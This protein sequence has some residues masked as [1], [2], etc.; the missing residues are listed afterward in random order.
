MK[1]E[2]TEFN[3]NDLIRAVV[4]TFKNELRIKHDL[5]IEFN[6]SHSQL[7]VHADRDRIHQVFYN[8]L[9]NAVKF[10]DKGLISISANRTRGNAVRVSTSDSGQGIDEG[11]LPKLFSKFATSSTGSGTGLGLFISQKLIEAHGGRLY[12]VNNKDK[13][14][15][16]QGGRGA[17]FTFILPVHALDLS[18]S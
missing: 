2:V 14:G 12:G 6:S 15:S 18:S 7:L 11:I 1:L 8:L 3:M 4:E 9:A 5:R 13:I 16:V 10:T 17:T